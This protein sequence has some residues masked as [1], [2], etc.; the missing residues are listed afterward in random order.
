MVLAGSC[1]PAAGTG[2]SPACDMHL[3]LSFLTEES[4]RPKNGV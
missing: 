1:R 3:E 2:S 4:T